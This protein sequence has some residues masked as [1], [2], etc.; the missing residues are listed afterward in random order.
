MRKIFTKHVLSITAYNMKLMKT[1]YSTSS[2]ST[3]DCTQYR[4]SAEENFILHFSID[5]T[6]LATSRLAHVMSMTVS[7]SQI[8]KCVRL[9]WRVYLTCAYLPEK[10]LGKTHKSIL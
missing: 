2:Q 1:S 4:M 10:T 6:L 8:V 9:S 7:S 5:A 3:P